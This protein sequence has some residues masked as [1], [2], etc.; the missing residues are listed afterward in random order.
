MYIAILRDAN[1]N[2]PFPDEERDMMLIAISDSEERSG[3][4]NDSI[5]EANSHAQL[6]TLHAIFDTHIA[7]HSLGKAI[8]V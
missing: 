8:Q 4:P 6:D 7:R 2:E 5:T 1:A 3:K